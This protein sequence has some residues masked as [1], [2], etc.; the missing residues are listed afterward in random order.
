MR[1]LSKEEFDLVC[2]C[3]DW[4]F[5]AFLQCCYFIPDIWRIKISKK[6]FGKDILQSLADAITRRKENFDFIYFEVLA[7]S[8]IN[9]LIAEQKAWRLLS[10]MVEFFL[11]DFKIFI[12]AYSSKEDFDNLWRKVDTFQGLLQKWNIISNYYKAKYCKD[13]EKIEEREE[14]VKKLIEELL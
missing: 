6:S 12:D 7:H 4:G 14:L 10:P 1:Q 13:W 11:E 2:K 3:K 5:G 9:P 8:L